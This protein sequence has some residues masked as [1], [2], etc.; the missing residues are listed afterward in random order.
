MT[1]PDPSADTSAPVRRFRADRGDAGVRLDRVLVRRL[2]DL[3]RPVSRSRIQAW[4][5]AGRVRLEG[6]PARPATRPGLGDRIEVELPPPPPPRRPPAPEAMELV[7][8]H[9][10]EHL[11]AVDK[12]P[13]L[14]AHPAPG[15]PGGTLLNGLIDRYRDDPRRPSIVTRLDE[16]TTGV[17]LVA[18]TR[19][20]HA[21]VHRQF[22]DGTV[23]KI[24]LAL[25]YGE[26]PVDVGRVDL[27]IAPHPEERGRMVASTRHGRE[28]STLYRRLGGTGGPGVVLTLLECRLE[29]GRTHQI[30][31]HLAALGCPLVGDPLYADPRWKGIEDEAL[32]RRCREF[33]RQALH[34]RRLV[35][36]HPVNGGTLRLEAPVPA[37][38]AH[39]LAAAGLAAGD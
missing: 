5:V 23:E 1:A 31:V 29:T 25:V 22:L 3:P 28:A 15:H 27:R 33:P 4:I 38:L 17:V 20:G 30:R 26:P 24:Y 21:G 11:V 37:D 16:D 19:E 6:E 14:V 36:E 12:P 2:A 8:L 18:R 34:A 39:L 13:G 7:V 10:D 9:E 35:L 32:A